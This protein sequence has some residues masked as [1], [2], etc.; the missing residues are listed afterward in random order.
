MNA[1][2]QISITQILSNAYQLSLILKRN[3]ETG[4][5]L[6]SSNTTTQ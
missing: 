1:N 5:D 3:C 4:V 6:F 2:M